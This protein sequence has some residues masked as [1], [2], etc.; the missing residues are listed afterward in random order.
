M[1]RQ[2]RGDVRP[3]PLARPGATTSV[4]ELLEQA[5]RPLPLHQRRDPAHGQPGHDHARDRRAGRAARRAWRHWAN[6]GYYGSVNHNVAATYVLYLGWFDGNP[7]TLHELPPESRPAS[8]TSS[9]WAAPTR[10]CR[11]R[12]RVL[13][14]GRLPLGRR[15]GQPRRVR[16]PRQP[17]GH[18]TCRPTRSSS[19]ATRPRRDR[20]ATS[21]SPAPRSCATASRELP[22]PNTASPD[23]VR[24][25][26]PRPVL[27]LPRR[28]PERRRRPATR[29]S[30]STS[31]SATAAATIW[32]SW[33]TACSTTRAGAAG[34]QRR[35]DGDPVARHAERDH[36]RRDQAR[37]RDR[38]RR[39][40]GRRQP[41][42][43]ERGGRPTSTPSS[44]GSTSSHHDV[45][46]IADPTTSRRGATNRS[47]TSP[48]T[49]SSTP[50]ADLAR[51]RSFCLRGT[52]WSRDRE[53]PPL[54]DCRSQLRRRA[55]SG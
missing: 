18:A 42:E 17:G 33:R 39:R 4:V 16:R 38:C 37:G 7:A 26:T 52:S 41:G 21:T 49:T 51:P 3:A 14:Q 28:A 24:A 32:S 29:R 15:G 10:C 34:R 53:T 40:Q 45:I 55:W 30:R 47:G 27:R 8:A 31:T 19:S 20:G 44:S 22:T 1:G 5:A 12:K 46:G 43:A 25:M 6:R 9:S 23:T 50:A 13:R 48:I 36:P 2:G 35:R 11:R 54:S